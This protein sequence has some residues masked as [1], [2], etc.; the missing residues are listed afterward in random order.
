MATKH[1]NRTK[2]AAVTL[3]QQAQRLL[4]KG[5]FKQ[6]LKDAKVCYRQQPGPEG[7]QLLERA[8]LARGRQLHRAGLRSESQAVLE[9][10]LDLGVTDSL[11][12][13]ELPELLIAVGLF[14]R[15]KAAGMPALS[16]EESDPLCVVVADHAV[17]RP[18]G[19]PTSLPAIRQGA[20]TIGKA[21]TALE[22]GDEARATAFLRDIP[23]AS[24]FADWK[25]FVRG[26]A[27]YYRDDAA[28]MEANWSRLDPGRCAARIAAPLKTLVDRAA[29]AADDPQV[30]VTVARLGSR[31]LGGPVLDRL[32]KLQDCV[33]AGRW[34]EAMKALRASGPMFREVDDALPER[35]AM[36]LYAMVVR[37]GD[38][39]ILRDLATVAEP[40]AID[41]RWN[42][43]LAMAWE[44]YEEEEYGG[45]EAER[46]W[47][48]YL[49]DL[50]R[51]ECLSPTERTLAQALVWLR[52]G[53]RLAEESFPVCPTC[54]VCHDPDK[55]MQGRAAACFENSLKLA[56]GLLKAYQALAGAREEWGEPKKAAAVYRRLLKRFPENLDALL[57]LAD[58]HVR[59]D[60]PFAAREFLIRAQR[61]K[62]LDPRI[63]EKVRDV[64]LS[65]AR[66]RA[67]ADRWDEGRAE[68]AA[69]GEVAR[70]SDKGYRLLVHRAM[71][72]LKA[73][74][75]GLA[76]RLLDQA[77]N[78]LG[79]SAPVWFLACI[80]GARYAL[81]QAVAAGLEDR[82][83]ASLK[84]GRNSPAAGEMSRIMF[85][86]LVAK[87]DH[88]VQE[89]HLESLV[90]FLKR[91]SRVKWQ[92]RDLRDVVQVLLYWD[93]H[94]SEDGHDSPRRSDPGGIV[95]LLAKLVAK[96]RA[97]FPDEPFLQ[98]IA[99]Q[100][101]MRKGS[102]KC[103]RRFAKECFERAARLA[104]GATD[105]DNTLV[106]KCARE[107][108][109]SLEELD[110]PTLET[111]SPFF[112]A[113]DDDDPDDPFDPPEDDD[114]T[115]PSPERT[116]AG[117]FEM[118]A[119]VC[120]EAGFSPQDVLD[121]IDGGRPARFSMS[122]DPKPKSKNRR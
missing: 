84:K 41:P 39:A 98:L 64:Y 8:Y 122:D 20:A 113:P 66:H 99:G 29:V 103:N 23:R 57:L 62:P 59:S 93:R 94:R 73:G 72:E 76:F 15:V 18:E 40:P 25:Y 36:V 46:H 83:V 109:R 5:D 17:L 7:R 71:L 3:V 118:F 34:R 105:P 82:W 87:V 42:R 95:K 120:R 44:R 102:R 106:G 32:Q 6:A 54:G 10:L 11:V 75:F 60:E 56:P 63:Q 27:A 48:A 92:A 101:E 31:V 52:L 12:E 89:E 96:G 97:K 88:A 115:D 1:K 119:R 78:D 45:N 14:G 100:L 58:H 74:D 110:R 79:E 26:L 107:A 43:G 2:R 121:E 33:L 24:P 85:A 13:R 104:E 86:Y 28:E 19:T 22:A 4:E 35:L 37:K 61:L 112:F 116:M 53:G 47:R 67:L 77:R 108:L 70:P 16:F 68:L 49:E 80:E 55:D 111:M 90:D 91:C 30:A 50:A 65:S 81:P 9:N 114:D 117:L 69:A 51:L 21:L 38:P